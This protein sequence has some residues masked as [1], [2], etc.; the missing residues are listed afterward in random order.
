MLG[1]SV[2]D[3]LQISL[4]NYGNNVF[5]VIIIHYHCYYQWVQGEHAINVFYLHMAV[6]WLVPCQW[7]W[8]CNGWWPWDCWVG[9]PPGRP[10]SPRF[11]WHGHHQTGIKKKKSTWLL[12]LWLRGFVGPLSTPVL[13][14]SIHDQMKTLMNE[15]VWQISEKNDV[16]VWGH[17]W[18]QE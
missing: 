8:Q 14:Y 10:I 2:V 16:N 17:Q 7:W 6:G 9:T 1:I 13:T 11:P 18:L 15:L 12:R 4:H 5:I 3:Q